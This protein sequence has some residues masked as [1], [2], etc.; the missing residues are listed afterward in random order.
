[1]EKLYR[2][3]ANGRYEDAGYTLPDITPGLY[4]QQNTEYGSRRTSVNYWLGGVKSEPVNIKRLLDYMAMDD[5]LSKYIAAIQDEKS[6]EYQQLKKD[7]GGYLKSPPK[8]YE[9]SNFDLSVAILRFLYN[10]SEKAS[11]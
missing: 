3:L 4:F 7:C 10:E 2:K 5:K 6:E 9:I 8:I 1:M 11:F